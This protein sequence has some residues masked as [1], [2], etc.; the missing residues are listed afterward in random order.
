VQRER[1]TEWF[2]PKFGPRNFRLFCGILFLPYTGMV[3]SFAAWGSIASNFS[4]ERLLA[5]CVLYLLALGVSAHLLDAISGKSKPWGI[6]SKKKI[7]TSSL[8]SLTF[9]FIIGL[10]YAFLDS[11]L[12]FP[13]GIAET[14]F[15]FTYNLELFSG[16]FHNNIVFVISWGILPVFAGSAIQ[17]NTI[18]L[19]SLILS[20]IAGSLSYVLI[21]TS[22]EYKKLRVDPENKLY[23]H[24]QEIVLKLISLGVIVATVSYFVS[25]YL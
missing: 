18:S 21:K 8:I 24:K 10:Y 25:R 3:V 14:F 15:L 13:I 2:V 1:F 12:L 7:L 20:G 23:P 5:I 22:K 16:K 9:A 11:P 17:T 19:E 4:V 6:L